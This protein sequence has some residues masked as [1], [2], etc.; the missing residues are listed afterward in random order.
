M[1]VGE[2][3]NQRALRDQESLVEYIERFNNEKPY[4]EDLKLNVVLVSSATG[5]GINALVKSLLQN[6]QPP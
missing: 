2:L 3:Q 4:V 1:G 6:N 5:L